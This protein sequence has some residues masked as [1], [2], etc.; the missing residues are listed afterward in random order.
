MISV[1]IEAMG[2][3]AVFLAMCFSLLGVKIGLM[4]DGRKQSCPSFTTDLF[5]ISLEKISAKSHFHHI[6]QSTKIWRTKRLLV[7]ATRVRRTQRTCAFYCNSTSTFR[8]ILKLI[9]DIEL[10]PRP[11]GSFNCSVKANTSS[12]NNVKI[13]HLMSAR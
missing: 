8:T 3:C 12:T 2:R 6:R 4:Q 11:N 10:N 13:D 7:L 9:F 1:G 5:G